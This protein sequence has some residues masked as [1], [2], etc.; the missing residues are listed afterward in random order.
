MKNTFILGLAAASLLAFSG[1]VTVKRE[2]PAS[3]NTTTTTTAAPL[4]PTTSSTTVQRTTT[5]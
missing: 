5:Y 4:A 1:C 3:T 2:T